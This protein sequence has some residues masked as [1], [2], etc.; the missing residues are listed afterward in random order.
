MLQT[1]R[2]TDRPTQTFHPR[3]PTEPA[4]ATSLL[5]LS[6]SF[7]LYT[8]LM[9]FLSKFKV[10]TTRLPDPNQCFGTDVIWA[11]EHSTLT[12]VRSW[13][14]EH[15]TGRGSLQ[16]SMSRV[17]SVGEVFVPT[18]DVNTPT[19]VVINKYRIIS[20]ATVLHHYNTIKYLVTRHM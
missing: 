6:I 5:H 2:Q 8:S 3:R 4:W 10:F 1:N 13:T 14:H 20:T 16:L 12:A 9:L 19:I 7:Q 18:T 15:P 17:T 11:P